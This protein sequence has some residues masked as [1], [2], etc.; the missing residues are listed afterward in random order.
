MRQ[1]IQQMQD[2]NMLQN[3]INVNQ[4][5][6]LTVLGWGSLSEGGA[7][8][9]VLNFV[10]LPYIDHG[11]CRAA[12]NPYKVFDGMFCAED[13]VKGKIGACQGDSDGPIVYRKVS[14]K[15]KTSASTHFLLRFP[16][17]HALRFL[18]VCALRFL[19]V[20]GLKIPPLHAPRFPQ[21]HTQERSCSI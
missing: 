14:G 5:P 3:L 18:Q 6:E 21:V 2:Q 1:T 17:V 8:A 4:A 11:T 13:I 15:Q 7:S 20:H 19:R 10:N 12:M 9:K 16:Q